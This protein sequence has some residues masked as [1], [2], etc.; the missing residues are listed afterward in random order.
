MKKLKKV[1][2]AVVGL[3]HIAQV[4]VLPAFKGAAKNS[5]LVAL[6][7]DDPEKAK[8]LSKKYKTASVYSYATYDQL[9][10]DPS[11][12]AVYISLPNHLH[13]EFTVRALN[14]GKHVLC[15]KPLALTEQDC[16]EMKEAA[17]KNNAKLMTAYRLH[18]EEAN[19][20]ALKLVNAGKLGEVRFF[21]STFSYQITD[22]NNIRLKAEDGGGAIWDIGIYCINAARTLM[23][24][25]PT[26][27]FAFKAERGDDKRFKEVP[28]GYSVLLKFP[29][30]RY[31]QFTCSFGADTTSVF[32]LTGTKGM[33][34]VENAYE[35]AG[36]RKLILNKDGKQIK[37]WEF[38]KV[39]QFA[40]ELLYF[41]DCVLKN[42]SVL[43][44]ASEGLNDVSVILAV[45]KSAASGKPIQLR[46]K[47]PHVGP[48]PK[49]KKR[50]AGHEEPELVNATGASS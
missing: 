12:D 13:K 18:F 17:Q 32:E 40:P 23:R 31:A 20:E 34:R 44:S 45:E 27:V 22:L 26:E 39:D 47:T 29:Q 43:P 10:G 8:K 36:K 15:E 9:L 49:M 14:S 35:Y 38:K 30:E 25:E 46:S 19:L 3:G 21:S 1:R 28:E 5:E 33:L 24:A 4:A 42:K 37:K 50:I 7:T 41:S 16:L 11:I 48:K 2:Y 6:V